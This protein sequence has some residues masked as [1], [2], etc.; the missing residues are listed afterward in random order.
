MLSS[1]TPAAA[2]RTVAAWF[3]RVGI[4]SELALEGLGQEAPE[5]IG[6]PL[7]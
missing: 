6:R 5:H 2:D 3:Q 1:I 4:A 7:G